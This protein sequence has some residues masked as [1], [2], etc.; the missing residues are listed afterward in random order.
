MLYNK[1][2]NDFGLSLSYLSAGNIYRKLEKYDS[3]FY[4][5]AEA[6]NISKKLK[7]TVG[8]A[9]AN[10]NLASVHFSKKE[11]DKAINLYNQAVDFLLKDDYTSKILAC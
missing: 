11:Y 4:V 2:G 10:Y 1:L 3:A 8:I 7:D 9:F 5:N 6:L